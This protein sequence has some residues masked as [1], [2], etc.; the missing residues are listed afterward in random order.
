MKII[1][2][3]LLLNSNVQFTPLKISEM[4]EKTFSF[5]IELIEQQ[6]IILNEFSRKAFGDV[7]E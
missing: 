7:Y 2:F 1:F 5:K 3:I 6:Q 4:S